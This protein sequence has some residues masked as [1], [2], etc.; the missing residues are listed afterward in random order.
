MTSLRIPSVVAAA[1]AFWTVSSPAIAAPLV[2]GA[3]QSELTVSGSW[4]LGWAVAVDGD[5]AIAGS[6]YENNQTGAAY[7]FAHAG[8]TWTQGAKL[9][10]S[11]S[12]ANDGF[13]SS[14]AL[15]GGWAIVGAPSA[16]ASAGAAYIFQQSGLSWSQVA[17]LS[18]VTAGDAFGSS[19][20]IDG[21]T[22]LVGA[23]YT[24]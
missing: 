16:A 18:G 11:D 14:V 19:V 6:P 24:I 7:L 21:E 22:G 12:A 17:V 4:R 13:G 20:A 5:S 10:G 23:P 2:I 3:Q 8:T 15:S 9:V 1:L